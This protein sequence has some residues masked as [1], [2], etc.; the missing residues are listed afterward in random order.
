MGLGRSPWVRGA[1]WGRPVVGGGRAPPHDLPADRAARAPRPACL[2]RNGSGRHQPRGLCSRVRVLL[3]V[4]RG[5]LRSRDWLLHRLHELVGPRAL[6]SAPRTRLGRMLLGGPLGAVARCHESASTWGPGQRPAALRAG[7]KGLQSMW[8]GRRAWARRLSAC[9]L[10][11]GCAWGP[12]RTRG[13]PALSTCSGGRWTCQ[14][15]PCPG[16]CSV[17]G[18]AHISTFDE[19]QYRVH[20]DCSYVLAKVRASPGGPAGSGDQPGFGRAERGGR[21]GLGP[22]SSA[23][24]PVFPAL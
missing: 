7:T 5:H 24:G 9:R 18:G 23:W 20:G 3:R 17:L 6:P 11:G 12:A 21:G 14:E 2:C 16:T 4:Q 1:L 19:K 22:T 8:G 13:L 15:A 10:G